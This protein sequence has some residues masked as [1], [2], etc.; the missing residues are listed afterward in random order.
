MR[1]TM[2]T[3]MWSVMLATSVSLAASVL[4][5]SPPAGAATTVVVNQPVSSVG[6]QWDNAYFRWASIP[7]NCLY[8]VMYIS[9][10]NMPDQN[11]RAR[12][13]GLV[14]AAYVSGKP[15]AI[16]DYTQAANGTCHAQLIQF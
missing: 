15:I 7:S 9:A 11:A 1:G 5:Q 16:V 3:R 14:M 4:W 2:R 12:A 13:L 8:G 10:D 6:V